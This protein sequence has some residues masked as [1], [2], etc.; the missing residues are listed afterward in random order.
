MHRIKEVSKR[1]DFAVDSIFTSA[2]TR[3]NHLM[4][5]DEEARAFWLEWFKKLLKIGRE[6]GAVTG[7]KSFW[8][9]N[10]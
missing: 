7:G 4:N 1:Y 3:V 8:Y 10:L 6:L 2:Y 5:P 9:F